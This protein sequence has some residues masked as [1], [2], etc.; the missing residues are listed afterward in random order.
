MNLNSRLIIR[1][2][3]WIFHSKVFS[4][5]LTKL[6][7]LPK[8]P[9]IPKLPELSKQLELSKLPVLPKLIKLPELP[10]VKYLKGWYGA[11]Y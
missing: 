7:E 2:D 11:K 8:L 3:I 10:E 9:E 5:E 6:P 1:R 4:S